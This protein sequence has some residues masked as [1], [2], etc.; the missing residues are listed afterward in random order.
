MTKVL[1][2]IQARSTST[3][4]PGKAL[5]VLHKRPVLSWVINACQD[6][7]NYIQRKKR[8]S[9]VGDV[10]L[11]VPYG[12]EISRYYKSLNILEG[13]EQDVLSRYIAA[14]KEYK[15]D[16]IVR[17]TGDCPFVSSFNITGHIFKALDCRLDYLSNV[18][19]EY[20]TELDG[21]DIEIF[22]S[23]AMEWLI[24]NAKTDDEKEHVTV[25]IRKEKPSSLKRGH[26]LCR[27][28]LSDI[29]LSIDTANELEDANSRIHSFYEKKVKAE[30]DVGFEN[31]FFA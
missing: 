31:V 8:G 29:K 13:D 9:I 22:S 5:A 4:L 30:K 16:Y 23:K 25:K 2:A 28:D 10:A 1:I 15:P 3:R 14:Y 26:F 6:S 24:E 17:I 7:V 18:D 11:L 19:E 12:D 20:R 21:K 27:L